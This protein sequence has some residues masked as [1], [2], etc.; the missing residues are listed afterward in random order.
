V[1]K[2][3][4]LQR[5]HYEPED[6][7][8]GN[9]SLYGAVVRIPSDAEPRCL[10][11]RIRGDGKIRGSTPRTDRYFLHVELPFL[12]VLDR[13]SARESSLSGGIFARL[14]KIGLFIPASNICKNYRK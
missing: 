5:S 12:I 4:Q 6:S 14:Q 7:V 8:F 3:A 13:C 10:V 2:R 1:L 11:S 9:S